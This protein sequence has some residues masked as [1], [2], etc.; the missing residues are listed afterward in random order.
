M[1]QQV[2][3]LI[4]K[5][6]Q[7]GIVAAEK[8]AQE[9]ETQARQRAENILAQAQQKSQEL[10]HQAQEEIKKQQQVS[11]LAIKQSARNLLLDLRK[12]INLTLNGILQK[13]ISSSL[14]PESTANILN[15]LIKNFIEKQSLPKDL[16]LLL[17]PSDVNNLKNGILGKLQQ[18]MKNP[19]LVRSSESVSKGFTISFDGGKSSFDF[20]DQGLT[21]YLSGYLNSELA[22]L[23]KESAKGS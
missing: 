19:I 2:Q 15:S 3:E 20:T 5:I 17:N 23:L 7:E 1:A 13:N 18:E 16:H 9:I 8:K 12:Q 21:D 6:K 14:T 11:Q 10:L 22:T 4:N